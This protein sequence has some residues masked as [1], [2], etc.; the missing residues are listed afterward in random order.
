MSSS[1]V[2]QEII[3]VKD[4]RHLDEVCERMQ[5]KPLLAIDTEFMRSRTYYPIAGLI[6]INDGEYNY[7]ID[8]T[9]IDD[10]YPLIEIFDDTSIYKCLHSCSEDLEVFQYSLGGLPKGMLDT[11]VAA[12]M[13]GYGFSVGFG[14]LV[15]AVID[16]ALPKG[17]TRSDWLQR[18]LSQAQLSY[19]A[20]DVEYLYIIAS[21]L[22]RRLDDIGRL[23]W[24]MED[25]AAIVDN[26][27]VN[28]DPEKSYL[29][30]KSAWKLNQRQL[31]V[32]MGLSRWR[33]DAAQ[34]QDVPRNRIVKES[35]IFSIAQRGISDAGQ[36]RKFEGINERMVRTYG[37]QIFE[38]VN[39]AL[40]LPE[41]ELPMLLPAPLNAKE[42]ELLTELKQ[43][44]GDVAERLSMANEILVKKKEYESL[45]V[46][47]RQGRFALP[48][49]LLGWR[50]EIV[51]D[52]LLA[53]TQRALSGD[54]PS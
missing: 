46:G 10:F 31:A 19:A 45:I 38:V 1:L 28:Q 5:H 7:L 27:F 22:I 43:K 12:A 8:P 36:L 16:I 24:A 9:T 21:Q 11:Q 23:H 17:E 52:M 30:F 37:Q 54:Q 35:A 39:K 15:S 34:D 20:I 44:V 13:A 18:P 42:R 33:E 41:S 50:R 48:E 49:Q 51:G 25:S 14:N 40:S 3:W 26:F 47:A 53:S 4:N 6:Q 32:L 29:R 2:K